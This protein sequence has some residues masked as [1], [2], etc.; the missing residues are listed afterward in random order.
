MVQQMKV[1][2][3]RSVAQLGMSGQIK[4]PFAGH[5]SPNFHGGS[6]VPLFVKMLR[7]DIFRS[8]GVKS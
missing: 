5:D 2:R 6:Q 8:S 4:L 1:V 7:N 3:N